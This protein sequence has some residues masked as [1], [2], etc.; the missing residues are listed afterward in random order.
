VRRSLEGARVGKSLRSLVYANTYEGWGPRVVGTLFFTKISR[1]RFR[2]VF[3]S[4]G[5]NNG[6][7]KMCPGPKF[8]M[9]DKWLPSSVQRRRAAKRRLAAFRKAGG[10]GRPSR[11]RRAFRKALRAAKKFLRSGRF[12]VGKGRKGRSIVRDLEP[13]APLQMQ[14]SGSN[15]KWFIRQ[16]FPSQHKQALVHISRWRDTDDFLFQSA[17]QFKQQFRFHARFHL[18]SKD[19]KSGVQRKSLVLADTEFGVRII[20]TLYFSRVGKKYTLIFK[21]TNSNNGCMNFCKAKVPFRVVNR[22]RLVK[23]TKQQARRIRKLTRRQRRAYRRR[24]AR[25]AAKRAA[26][27]ARRA[28]KKKLK[29]LKKKLRA[30][31][32]AKRALRRKIRKLRKTNPKRAAKLL[33]KLKKLA[34]KLRAAKRKLTLAKPF[35][36]KA[37]RKALKALKKKAAKK[38]LTRRQ[39]AARKAIAAARKYKYEGQAPTA[40][41]ASLSKSLDGDHD[42][43]NGEFE[44]SDITFQQVLK[45]AAKKAAAKQAAAR[46][47]AAVKAAK[48][49]A[50]ASSTPGAKKR[51]SL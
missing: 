44:A 13:T 16:E 27:K 51:P 9:K 19:F 35:S 5:S 34:R 12:A 3:T 49:T 50:V 31:K 23:R 28:L 24:A 15:W 48:R 7:K 39:R 18:K 33:R 41:V 21:S 40:A 10:R 11:S 1:D 47:K 45:V 14:W 29:A 42:F 46:V 22:F 8:E 36:I 25:R 26:R 6:C 17:N 37:A 20:G 30:L 32:K 2:S 4:A 38:K 43:V